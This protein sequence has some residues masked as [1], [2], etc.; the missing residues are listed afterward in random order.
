MGEFLQDSLLSPFRMSLSLSCSLIFGF[1]LVPSCYAAHRAHLHSGEHIRSRYRL[2]EPWAVPELSCCCSPCLCLI[3]WP[4][5]SLAQGHPLCLCV[6][7]ITSCPVHDPPSL[8]LAS[9]KVLLYRLA[10]SCV[11][12]LDSEHHHW[13]L[14]LFF[15]AA[16]RQNS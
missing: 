9:F 8:G 7:E 4:Q 2:C 14:P 11:F 16:P 6:S 10:L 5:E 15:Q 13:L 1:C 3:I 12:P